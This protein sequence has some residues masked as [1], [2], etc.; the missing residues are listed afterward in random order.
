MNTHT[1]MILA[2]SF[3]HTIKG[4][5]PL[6]GQVH[7]NTILFNFIVDDLITNMSWRDSCFLRVMSLR[8][9]YWRCFICFQSINTN[10]IYLQDKMLKQ[11]VKCLDCTRDWTRIQRQQ[12]HSSISLR[13]TQTF[14]VLFKLFEARCTIFLSTISLRNQQH[15]FLSTNKIE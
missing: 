5:M 4:L 11:N 9:N 3:A 15:M 7:K 10:F 13:R 1:L 6:K 12:K 2:S 8:H 14:K